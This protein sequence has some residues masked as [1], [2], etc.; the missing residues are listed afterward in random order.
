MAVIQGKSSGWVGSG[1]AIT[2]VMD[3]TPTSGN[4]LIAFL[5][6]EGGVGSTIDTAG[7][8]ERAVQTLVTTDALQMYSAFGSAGDTIHVATGAGSTQRCLTV[9]EVDDDIEV[10]DSVNNG[11]FIGGSGTISGPTLVQAEEAGTLLAAFTGKNQTYVAVATFTA[12][13][14]LTAFGAAVRGG[15][16]H[17]WSGEATTAD[18]SYTPQVTVTGL[19]GS[20]QTAVI[21]VILSHDVP[22]API[23]D[24]TVDVTDG[25]APFTA[26][27]EDT[28]S[29][30]PTSWLWD[31]GDG[32]TS[33]SQDPSH[34]YATPGAFTVT[35]TATNAF[36]SDSE[37][38]IAYINVLTEGGF[39]EPLPSG[40]LLEIYAADPSSFRWGVAKWGQATWGSGGWQ[41]VTPEG[42]DIQILWGAQ[43]PEMGILSLP[44]ADSWA[45]T[46][47]DPERRLDPANADGPFYTDLIPY[48]PVRVS[49]RERVIALGY[50]ES[51]GHQYAKST[52]NGYM[53]V[54]NNLSRLANAAVPSDTALSDTLYARAQDAIAAAGLSLV[55]GAALG[56][57]PPLV[58]WA[59]LGPQERSAWAWIVDAA[60]QAHY[61]PYVNRR[62][63]IVEFRAWAS[64]LNRGRS[65]NSPELVDLQVISDY[66]GLFSVIRVLD[67]ADIVQER[68]LIPPP[69][70]GA[71]VFARTDPT[72]D[73]EE[74]AEI[75]LADRGTPGY[76]WVP[77]TVY[78]LTAN[79]VETLNDIA[80]VELISMAVPEQDPPVSAAGIVVGGEIIITGKRASE[81]IWRFKFETAQTAI[82]P[83][84]ET[85]GAPTDYLLATGGGEFLYPST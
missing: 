40:V 30:T 53:R 65:I 47:Y 54:T 17:A 18:G 48:L 73:A 59:A 82:E 70:Y 39:E 85:G 66:R 62:T 44:T 57:D 29:G 7:W 63:G 71:R 22:D 20:Y 49:H 32:S 74:W 64:P 1:L 60:R 27:F 41:D 34:V 81:A 36:G 4:R 46:F 13:S 33:T 72:L 78:P 68:A 9:Y 37:T 83:L 5:W 23:A 38:K 84:I 12:V 45:I 42:V 69:R 10:F 50:A 15:R 8:T 28:S 76:R 35:L 61:I 67:D 55:V 43:D 11:A 24:F 77:G 52:G 16:M 25:E 14:P 56:T 21:A 19:T 80:N 2:L 6:T 3:S 58:P 79:S 51:I 75:V 31:F 26:N